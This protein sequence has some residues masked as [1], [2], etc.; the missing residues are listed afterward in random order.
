MRKFTEAEYT[1]EMEKERSKAE[2]IIND[3]DTFDKFL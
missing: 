3:K 1:A 2:S